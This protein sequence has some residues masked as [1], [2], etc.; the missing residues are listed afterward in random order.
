MP[1]IPSHQLKAGIAKCLEVAGWRLREAVIVLD[2]G[3]APVTAAVLFSFA[4]EEFGKAVL[5]YD[6]SV[7]GEASVEIGNF[8]DHRA[9]FSAAVKRIPEQH[10]LLHGGAF[11]RDF[12]QS[13]AFDVGNVVDF[14]AR[15]SG[16][17]VEWKGAWQVG[18]RV[19]P[20]LLRK[21]IAAVNAIIDG[22]RADWT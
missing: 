8:Y 18:V 3:V 17:Y 12:V 1:R 7:T 11:Q 2:T 19:D 14:D 13:N 16:L 5:L 6:A 9:K 20:E 21:N 4:I 10:L 15:L 22:K